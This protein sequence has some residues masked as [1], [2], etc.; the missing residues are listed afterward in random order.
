M[1]GEGGMGTG[2][3]QLVRVSGI[4]RGGRRG[5]RG[6]ERGKD[7]GEEEEVTGGRRRERNWGES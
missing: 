4:G 3:G 6:G 7:Q 1:E 5:G 2:R